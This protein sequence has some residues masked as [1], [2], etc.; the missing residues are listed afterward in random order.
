MRDKAG[1]IWL[2]TAKGLS[3]FDPRHKTIQFRSFD[4]RDGLTEDQLDDMLSVT[5]TGQIYLGVTGG[6]TYFHPDSLLTSYAAPPLMIYSLKIFDNEARLD[7][8]IEFKQRVQLLADENFFTLSFALL[9]YVNPEKN[10][11]RYKLEGYD[12]QWNK[13]N[14]LN[15]ATYKNVPPG[16][17]TF[18]VKAT[19]NHGGWQ[20]QERTLQMVI[21]PPWWRTWWAYFGYSFLALTALWVG[22]R[23]I[24]KRERLKADLFI[25]QA[26]ADQLKEL[27]RLK[28]RFFAN[29]SHE[30]GTPLT[31]V[32]NIVKDKM[33]LWQESGQ[34]AVRVKGEELQVMQRNAQ[35]LLELIDQ[36]LDLSKIEAGSLPLN[37]QSGDLMAFIRYI[38]ASFHSLAESRRIQ[39]QYGLTPATFGASFD[40][41]K[42]EKIVT[43][44]LSNAFKFTPEGGKIRLEVTATKQT[45]YVA[46]VIKVTDSGIGISPDEQSRIFE[47]FYQVDTSTTRAYE[48]SG[49]GLALSKEL[50]ELYGGS[51]GVNSQ[52]GEGTTFTVQL[53]LEPALTNFLQ[54]AAEALPAVSIEAKTQGKKTSE[55]KFPYEE[56]LLI[57]EDNPDLS[58]YLKESLATTYQVLEASNG[59][60]A[61]QIALAQ[62]PDLLISD[63]MMP[64]MDG[65]TLCHTLKT[66]ERTSHIPVILL[67]A[68]A[69]VNNK[70]E[71][72]QTGAD[73]Y[74]VKPFDSRELLIRIKNL[75]ENRK[76][77]RERYAKE[78]I[79][80]STSV[81]LPSADEKFLSKLRDV[82]E[83]NLSDEDFTV[84]ELGNT[85]ALSRVQLYRKLYALTNQSPS[86]LIRSMRLQKAKQ[87][88]ESRVGNISEI[89]YQVGFKN[90][91]YFSKSFSKEFGLSPSDFLLSLGAKD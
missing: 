13:A 14:N 80:Q 42:I 74:L 23:E 46:V 9:H 48:G 30:F 38:A 11:Y 88:L 66:D 55:G 76:K 63:V 37:N 51:I 8:A 21:L 6:I 86:D 4:Q 84:E 10:Q 78:F 68:R 20:E 70:L 25:R 32:L 52:P 24:V 53:V 28:S 29:I 17:Y 83:K 67:T 57:V 49:I 54:E 18:R 41:D 75:L 73:D 56:K 22:R 61:L 47:R 89:G 5:E 69:G 1:R 26:E 81:A 36:L 12:V 34:T 27:D 40:R 35:R 43:N 2:S 90:P 31:L 87:L 39:Y 19:S 82:I 77:S 44:L 16:A 3:C 45:Q 65:F 58:A 71:G 62:V 72:L 79:L 85:M 64:L 15:F 59:A 91:G 7:S 33:S 50:V 60:E